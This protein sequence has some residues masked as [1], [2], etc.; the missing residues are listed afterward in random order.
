MLHSKVFTSLWDRPVYSSLAISLCLMFSFNAV[1]A[2]RMILCYENQ[3][4][5]PYLKSLPVSDD[6][7]EWVDA[8]TGVLPDLVKKAADDLDIDVVFVNYPW[9]RC[10]DQLKHGKVDGIFPAIWTKARDSWG[11]FPK[12]DGMVYS[13]YKLWHV[14]YLIYAQVHSRLAWDGESFT[15]VFSGVASPVGYITTQKL[16]QLGV[17]PAK[18]FLPE[19]GFKLAALGRID[20]YVVEESVGTHLLEKLKLK[21]ELKVLPTPFLMADWYLPLSSQ[22]VEKH[23]GLAEKFWQAIEKHRLQDGELLYHFYRT[24]K[25]P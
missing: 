7:A 5:L 18:N 8:E 16:E 25:L 13:P 20:G 24:I 21:R 15:G 4:Y 12:R 6:R 10:I 2:E 22:W 14:R 3:D 17:L 19:Q 1:A 11:V 9:L 23:P